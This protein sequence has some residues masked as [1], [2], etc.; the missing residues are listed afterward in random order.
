MSTAPVFIDRVP[1]SPHDLRAEVERALGSAYSLHQ[2]KRIFWEI[3]GYERR[4]EPRPVS[5]IDPTTRRGLIEIRLFASYDDVI[6]VHLKVKNVSKRSLPFEQLGSLF[7][8]QR[9]LVAWLIESADEPGWS[10]VYQPESPDSMGVANP[11]VR[12]RSGHFR[13][14]NRRQSLFLSKLGTSDRDGRPLGLSDL[15]ASYDD[16]FTVNRPEIG[17]SVP[18]DREF[19]ERQGSSDPVLRSGPQAP[20]PSYPLYPEIRKF[21]FSPGLRFGLPP[22]TQ[23]DKVPP[24]SEARTQLDKVPPPSV[25][26]PRPPQTPKAPRQGRR[27]IPLELVERDYP[28]LT[29]DQERSILEEIASV[30]WCRT[31]R[32]GKRTK[33]VRVPLAGNESRFQ[34]LRDRLI[35]HNLYSCSYLSRKHAKDQD[36]SD[37]LFQ[38]SALSIFRAIDLMDMTGT[39]RFSWHAQ[40][41]IRQDILRWINFHRSPVR[42]AMEPPPNPPGSGQGRKSLAIVGDIQDW[43]E[44]LID[45]RWVDSIDRQ[46]VDVRTS[47]IDT[48]LTRLKERSATII[49]LRFGLDGSGPR[50]LE[51]IAQTLGLTRERVRQIEA[52]SLE[53]LRYHLSHHFND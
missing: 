23:L 13:K 18:R 25:D 48:A 41:R 7:G 20:G 38:E 29:M 32:R 21:L 8:R 28:R 26:R 9:H 19:S 51:Q 39:H 34:Q 17:P 40:V 22:R 53:K 43:E 2:I 42:P 5:A 50:T 6:F 24:P 49:R 36:E 31:T 30:S 45:D 15:L 47:A 14:G 35:S 11:P 3:L 10:I 4:D 12:H 27:G 52:K 44:S 1:E 46:D 37:E 16:A 33:R